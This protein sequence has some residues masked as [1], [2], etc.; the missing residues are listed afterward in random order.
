MS[1]DVTGVSEGPL[2]SLEGPSLAGNL[3]GLPQTSNHMVSVD[4]QN[5][6]LAAL[7]RGV[8]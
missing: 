5:F 2:L 7:L 8:N 1:G 4:V 6:P 3:M